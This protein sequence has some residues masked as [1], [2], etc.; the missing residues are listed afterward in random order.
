MKKISRT[1][2]FS[3]KFLLFLGFALIGIALLAHFWFRGGFASIY[4]DTDF[5]RDLSE[6]SN[7]WLHHIV[8]LGPQ[9]SAGFPASPFYY[10]LFFP[11][12]L[13]SGGDPRALIIANIF[14][15]AF[16]LGAFSW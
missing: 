11:V 8:W 7:I 10:Y 15:A 3:H 14:L 4:I 2:Y 1:Q 6:L 9:L 12:L 16:C 13:L 5:G